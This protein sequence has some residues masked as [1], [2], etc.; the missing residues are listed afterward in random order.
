MWGCPA[1]ERGVRWGSGLS[2]IPGAGSPA[3]RLT[4]LKFRSSHLTVLTFAIAHA[5]KPPVVLRN[6]APSANRALRRH[7]SHQRRSYV[8]FGLL[9]W[10]GFRGDRGGG[11]TPPF[12]PDGGRAPGVPPIALP[13]SP[14]PS[15]DSHHGPP[16]GEIPG[17]SVH[18][19][20]PAI[21]THCP[22]P[23]WAGEERGARVGW[24]L[25]IFPMG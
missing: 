3:S 23:S 2:A 20:P 21:A 11:N 4:V 15:G 17:R 22:R 9:P 6:V 8:A 25:Q 12:P 14:S 24:G 19:F 18:G 1:G 10:H 5:S 7:H 13:V 16:H